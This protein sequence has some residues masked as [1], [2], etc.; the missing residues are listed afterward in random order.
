MQKLL[1]VVL[2][3]SIGF[4][5]SLSSAGG[6]KKRVLA[7]IGVA[8]V[9]TA[10]YLANRK[11]EV[12]VKMEVKMEHVLKA[13]DAVMDTPQDAIDFREK[14][15]TFRDVYIGLSAV[16]YAAYLRD[17][18]SQGSPASCENGFK[19][20]YLASKHFDADAGFT[21]AVC[22]L[23][24]LVIAN[25]WNKMQIE[26]ER[27]FDPQNAVDSQIVIERMRSEEDKFIAMGR[28][29]RCKL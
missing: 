3:L 2:A 17:V 25:R 8:A 1:S 12:P 6:P 11:K 7:L 20:A 13:Y 19:M 10:I 5:P 9:G 27:N 14:L 26:V 22:Q 18:C 28:S 21:N 4:T 24:A 16:A 29:S 23:N 15:S